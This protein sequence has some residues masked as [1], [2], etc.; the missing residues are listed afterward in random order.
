MRKLFLPLFLLAGCATST[1]PAAPAT[2]EA[3]VAT[4]SQP[5]N[6][7]HALLHAV[8]WTQSSAEHDASTL[9]IFANARR[10]LDAALADP[11]WIGAT[12][13]TAN[14]P[15]QPPAVILDLD[16]TVIDNAA[17]EVHFMRLGKTYDRVLWKEWVAKAAA[18]EVPGAKE[19]LLYAKSRGVMA[20]YISNRDEDERPGT[21]R[22]LEQLGLPLSSN[23]ENMLL[24]GGRPEWGSDKSSRR[25]YV[26]ASYRVLLLFGDDLNDFANAREASIEQRDAIVAERKEWWGTRWFMIPNPMYGSWEKIVA[27]PTGT[28]CEQFQ[29]KMDAL[30]P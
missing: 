20:F 14:D 21:Q 2:A 10:A 11:A 13:E 5:C 17:S 26:A 27:G 6:A 4:Q 29:R 15:S 12:E 24:R 3:A 23:P 1:Q 8:L 18:L 7:H 30:K 9:G 25:A 22:T 19:F 28:P 16:E